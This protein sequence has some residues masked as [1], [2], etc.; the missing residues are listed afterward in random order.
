MQAKQPAATGKAL[1]FRSHHVAAALVALLLVAATLTAARAGFE[2]GGHAVIVYGAQHPELAGMIALAPAGQPGQL[3]NAPGIAQ[4]IASARQMV[5]AGQ[6]G[7]RT[8]FMDATNDKTPT[9]TTTP[10]I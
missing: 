3:V 9:V 4:M 2:R 8:G 10:A 1:L 5:A 7:Q 6:G